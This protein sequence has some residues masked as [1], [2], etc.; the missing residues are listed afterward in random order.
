MNLA[1][2]IVIFFILS[3]QVMPVALGVD[4]RKTGLFHLISIVLFLVAGQVLLFLMGVWLG[5]RFMH[6]ISAIQR[7]VLFVGFFLIA[8]RYSMEAFKI[9]K[10]ERTYAIEKPALFIL[11][12]IA[13]AMNTFLAGILLY[14]IPVDLLTD[15]IYLSVFSL[16][17]TLLF[18]FI[19][20]DKLSTSAISLLYM[21]GGGILT[22]VSIYFAFG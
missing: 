19:K 16:I 7:G 11:P 15:L 10:G 12:A 1:V 21:I 20:N 8:V 17:F 2:S 6:L 18:V 9:R 13:Q 3:F 14:F 4:A 5:N 22:L